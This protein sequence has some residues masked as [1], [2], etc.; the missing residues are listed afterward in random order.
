MPGLGAGRG[1]RGPGAKETQQP[2]PHSP[3]RLNPDWCRLRKGG[4]EIFPGQDARAWA[5]A[6]GLVGAITSWTGPS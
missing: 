5:P 3:D 4:T 6:P 2:R 1:P